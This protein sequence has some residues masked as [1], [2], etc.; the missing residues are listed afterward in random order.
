VMRLMRASKSLVGERDYYDYASSANDRGLPGEALAVLDLGASTNNLSAAKAAPL[1]TE[2]SGRVA[3][4]RKSLPAS[5]TK[6]KSAADGKMAMNTADAFLGY[7]DY[8][9]A[10]EL[11]QLAL[12]K[13]GVDANTVN[14]RL[15]IALALG[16]QK[17]TA[18]TAFAAVTGPR[19]QVA[20]FW[21]MWLDQPP[22]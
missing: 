10:A 12:Q 15:G 9:K 20:T 19:Q 1:R 17:D 2:I 22:A 18:R 8:A 16:G 7:G 3:E 14:T 6:A 13:G 5:Y 4:D 21:T 11:Y